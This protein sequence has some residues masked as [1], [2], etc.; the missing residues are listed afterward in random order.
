[1]N[2]SLVQYAPYWEDIPSNLAR[3]S[4]MFKNLEKKTDLILLPEM[5]ATGFSTNVDAICT[6]K[7]RDEALQWMR[8]QS[9]TTGAMIAGGVATVENQQYYNRFYWVSPDGNIGHYD[10][11]YLFIMSD[12]PKFFTAGTEKKDF[13]WNGWKFRPILCYDLRFPELS[14][15]NGDTPYDVLICAASWPAVRR[16]VWLSLLKARAIE[17]QSYVIGINR[18]GEDAN[19]LIHKGDSIVYSPKGKII[20]QISENEEKIVTVELSLDTL[21]EFRTNFPVLDSIRY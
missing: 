9:A 12:E 6:E 4:D 20:A 3:L 14:R 7:N 18:V 10:K 11:N 5:F 16:D 8:K 1:M 15:N 2:V 17:N 13:E 21:K 19:A